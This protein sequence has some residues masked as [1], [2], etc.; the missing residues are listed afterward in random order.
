MI[1]C[2]ICHLETKEVFEVNYEFKRDKSELHK[3][4]KHG[5][6]LKV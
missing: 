5:S 2:D 6:Q 4:I 1:K 3:E